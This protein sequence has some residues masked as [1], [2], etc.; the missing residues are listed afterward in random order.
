MSFVRILTLPI[1]LVGAVLVS[2]CA[3][4][5][6][7]AMAQSAETTAV[8]R[9]AQKGYKL[10][11]WRLE[12]YLDE[13]R[14][15]DPQRERIHAVKDRLF[16]DY[17][18]LREKSKHVP[19]LALDEWDSDAIDADRLHAVVDAQMDQMRQALHGVVDA[20]VE[21]HGTLTRDQRDEISAWIRESME[22]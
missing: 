13:L 4:P 6:T 16:D 8:D 11:S 19:K 18:R 9:K 5:S 20:I 15:T 2:A 22:D 17:L 21:T 10:V 7:N 1:A 12:G 3:Q 14:A